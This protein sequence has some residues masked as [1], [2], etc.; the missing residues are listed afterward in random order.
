M[1]ID[2]Q[3]MPSTLRIIQDK[4]E[5][6]RHFAAAGIPLGP[7]RAIKC[8]GCT[9]AAATQFGFPY[10]LKSRRLAYDGRGN[11][12]VAAPDGLE[13]A[14]AA[15]GG[16]EQGLYAEAWVPYVCELAVMVARSRSGEV[17]SFPVVQTI[18]KDSICST[19]EAPAM[20]AAD[21]AA[22]AQQVAERAVA[23]LEGERSPTGGGGGGAWGRGAG[24]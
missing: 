12:V 1:G 9:A 19:T 14:L 15:L 3:P 10:M 17:V 11:A 8:A 16:Y 4:F 21:V 23:C 5:Q 7:F 18:H 2:V 22:R 13:A 20:V 6:K 24:A